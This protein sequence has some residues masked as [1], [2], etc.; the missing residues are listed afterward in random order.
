MVIFF[1]ISGYLITASWNRKRDPFSYLIARALRIFPGLVLLVLVTVF[2]LGPLM[3]TSS[4]GEYF[5]LPRTWSYLSNIWLRPQYDLPGV[6]ID[7]PYPN[8]VNGSLWTLP[9][10][11]FCYLVVPLLVV[12]P[13]RLRPLTVAAFLVVSLGSVPS[14][15][16]SPRWSTGRASRTRRACGCSS[17]A[18]ACSVSR[19]TG[20]VRVFF[21]ADVAVALV[22]LYAV[23][24][25][26]VAGK[27][28]WVSWVALPYAVLVIGLASTPVVRRAARYG[29]MSYG[30]YLWAFPVQQVLV[31]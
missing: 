2:V 5:D 30:L 23:F 1:S 15:P 17:P 19:W 3:T 27:T 25:A 28:L 31:L 20:G 8:A 12:W 22:S 14:P 26:V 4:T 7:I 24:I 13:R 10:E 21:R 6:F 18:A 16:S 11:F 9:A 29:D